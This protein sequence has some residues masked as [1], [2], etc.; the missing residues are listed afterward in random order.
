VIAAG[1]G[2]LH[3]SV[4][5]PGLSRIVL[6]WVAGVT[7]ILACICACKDLGITVLGHLIS[8]CVTPSQPRTLSN[9]PAL[10]IL[11]PMQMARLTVNCWP[12]YC[13]MKH[14][15]RAH[16]DRTQQQRSGGR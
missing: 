3:K 14:I 15:S 11:T 16:K 13:A 6:G 8:Y 12:F 9:I 1:A 2:G 7:M 10:Q 5:A 4:G